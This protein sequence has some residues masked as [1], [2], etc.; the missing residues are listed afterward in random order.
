MEAT[1]NGFGGSGG[2]SLGLVKEEVVEGGHYLPCENVK[3]SA[4]TIKNWLAGELARWREVEY[5]FAKEVEA[6]TE[7]EKQS[8]DP[9]FLKAVKALDLSTPLKSRISKL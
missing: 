3:R 4:E 2:A 7:A 6:K 9:K 8:L 1:G 5:A